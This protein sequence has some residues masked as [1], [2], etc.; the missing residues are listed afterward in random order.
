MGLGFPKRF[1][2]DA[3]GPQLRNTY[4]VENPETDIGAESFNADFHQ[5]SGMNLIVPRAAL[6]ARWNGS[7]FDIFH[8]EEAWNPRHAQPHPV[9]ERTVTGHYTYT[10]ASS[11]EDEEGVSVPTVLVAARAFDLAGTAVFAN[12]VEAHA[13]IDNVNPL[14]VHVQLWRSASG[15]AD[16]PRFWLEVL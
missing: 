10:F 2:R 11:Y 16:D 12:R 5:V 6:V 8:Q 14:I 9:L 13:W 1:T 7:T 15:A 3:L 4:P